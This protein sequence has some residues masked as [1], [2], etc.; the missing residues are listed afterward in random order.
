MEQD[1]TDFLWLE[2]VNKETAQ[3]TEIFNL[4]DSNMFREMLGEI[5]SLGYNIHHLA[6]L[7]FYTFPNIGEIIK[8]YIFR[9]QSEKIRA[10]LLEQMVVSRLPDCGEILLKLYCNYTES[11][12]QTPANA[13]IVARYDNAFS[14]CK[15]KRIKD[16]L[17]TLIAEPIN[18]YQLPLTVKMLSSWKVP[19]CKEIL[20]RY[21][22]PENITAKELQ[23]AEDVNDLTKRLLYRQK[24]LRCA[25]IINLRYYPSEEVIL[26]LENIK[27]ETD[28][29]YVQAAEKSLQYIYKR[30]R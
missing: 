27:F 4:E 25:A 12:C 14:H 19:Q 29:D 2:A 26:L 1:Y 20:L 5:N 22:H 16:K 8:K 17:V 28:C 21:L 7:D 15:P 9:F 10:A 13:G 24:Q 30:K 11:M 23:I 6:T 18:A 3:Q